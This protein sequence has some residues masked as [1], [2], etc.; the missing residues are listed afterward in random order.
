MYCKEL[1]HNKDKVLSF[2]PKLAVIFNKYD[3]FTAKKEANK[4]GRYKKPYGNG[5]NK[6]I[7]INQLNYWLEINEKADR[8]FENGYYWVYNT[9]ENW[10]ENDFPFW[11]VDTVKRVIT[12][13]ENSGVVISANY[14]RM[15]MDKTKWYRI[16]YERLQEIID[17]VC[18]PKQKSR[19]EG[20]DHITNRAD[21]TVEERNEHKAIPEIT[22][23]INKKNNK[24]YISPFIPL[25]TKSEER[26]MYMITSEKQKC[27]DSIEDRKVVQ[28]R[29]RPPYNYTISQLK[30]FLRWKIP[31]LMKRTYPE[32]PEDH[33]NFITDTITCFY[34]TYMLKKGERHPI[35]SDNTYL[36]IANKILNPIWDIKENGKQFCAQIYK[37]MM[38]I[39][40]QTNYGEI[41]G[42]TTDY[43]LSYFL[44]PIVQERLYSKIIYQ[45]SGYSLT[46]REREDFVRSKRTKYAN[47]QM[48]IYQPA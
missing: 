35:L 12:S 19:K 37:E 43:H 18:C 4:T 1:L 22:T 39:Y 40:F 28:K 32:E 20:S 3:E 41:S 46:Q 42:N 2:F 23:E 9:Y 8:N 21:C 26:D 31:E 7:F 10:V 6:A 45:S 11:S 47:R 17:S 27:S 13:L 24:K 29:I 44:L 36:K 14:N 38:E 48:N 16:D 33:V 5:L 34:G 30:G 15:K 25:I